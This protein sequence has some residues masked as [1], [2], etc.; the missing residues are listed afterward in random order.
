MSDSPAN[1]RGS[2]MERQTEHGYWWRYE[3]SDHGPHDTLLAAI[4]IGGET[5]TGFAALITSIWTA[6]A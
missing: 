2:I 3:H 1:A 4:M 6:I 5:G